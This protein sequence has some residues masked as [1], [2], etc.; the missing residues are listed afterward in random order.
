ML[1]KR[2]SV[3]LPKGRDYTTYIDEG[4]EIE[5][6]FSFSGSVLV[7]GHLHGEIISRDSLIVGEK[8]VVNAS[9]Q[10]DVVLISGE[11]VGAVSAST[12]L[13]LLGNARVH[14]DVVA[15]VV[16][17]EEGALLEGHCRM[18]HG[19]RPD[20]TPTPARDFTVV[21]LKREQPR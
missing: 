21:P 16:I 2:R 11:V 6:K 19:R 8:A 7:N 15:P 4:S 18:T 12:R 20:S 14:G 9:I 3:A 17:I 13:E 5:G 1:W 10:G